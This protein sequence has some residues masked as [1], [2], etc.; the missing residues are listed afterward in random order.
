MKITDQS[1]ISLGLA[2]ALCTLAWKSSKI[3]SNAM[4]AQSSIKSIQA[5]LNRRRDISDDKWATV[6]A[7][8]ASLKQE[9]KSLKEMLK[10]NRDAL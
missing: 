3:D 5:Y 10:S 1:F 2:L 7:D 4:G 9:V 6:I 8:L